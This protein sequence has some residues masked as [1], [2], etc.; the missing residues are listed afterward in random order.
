MADMTDSA[1]PTASAGDGHARHSLAGLSVSE[2]A[3]VDLDGP[4]LEMLLA[5]LTVTACDQADL[6]DD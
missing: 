3:E 6:A 5:A 1:V 4:T 2:L